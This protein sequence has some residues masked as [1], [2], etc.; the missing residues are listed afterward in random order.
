[1][2]DVSAP[3]QTKLMAA[4]PLLLT[5][6][7]ALLLTRVPAVTDWERSCAAATAEPHA[8]RKGR[9]RALRYATTEPRACFACGAA[10]LSRNVACGRTTFL[11]D[12]EQSAGDTTFY[13]SVTGKPLFYARQHGQKRPP[14]H[15]QRPLARATV[16]PLAWAKA[17][18]W[19][20]LASATAPPEGAA[21]G[22]GRLGTPSRR[23]R[24]T[25]RST[26][27]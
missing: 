3:A 5:R 12:E 17:A 4:P 19:L 11:R 25:G 21:G 14:R 13:D 8:A 18:P 10:R 20:C 26:L 2:L 9:S 1:M 27:A 23:G 24:L 6:V 16:P 7:S 22:S 15:G